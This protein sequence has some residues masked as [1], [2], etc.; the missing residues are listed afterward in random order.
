MAWITRAATRVAYR[1]LV[2]GCTPLHTQAPKDNTF[3]PA[4]PGHRTYSVQYLPQVRIKLDGHLDEAQWSHVT[5]ESDF[6]FHSQEH[7]APYTDFRALCDD[8][9]FYFASRVMDVDLF[10]LAD[11]PEKGFAVFEDRVEMYFAHD[12][13]IQKYYCIEIDLHGR[14]MD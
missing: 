12:D 14:T 7:T 2:L 9:Y 3:P 11:L 13:Q 6:I 10:V 8:D 4:R 1:V 5:I